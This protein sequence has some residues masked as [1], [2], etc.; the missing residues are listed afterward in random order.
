MMILAID[1]LPLTTNPQYMINLKN[2][3][4]ED[5]NIWCTLIVSLMQKGRRALRDEG[6]KNLTIGRQ[7]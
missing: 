4:E 7:K 3:D 6:E 5:P 2:V 1:F